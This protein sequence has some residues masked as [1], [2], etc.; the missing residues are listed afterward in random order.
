[1]KVMVGDYV[2]SI[3][4]KEDAFI[5]GSDDNCKKVSYFIINTVPIHI[6]LA[7]MTNIVQLS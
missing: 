7:A 4:V 3:D 2:N 1:M 6:A 5:Y